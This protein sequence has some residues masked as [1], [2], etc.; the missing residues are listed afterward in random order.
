MNSRDLAILKDLQR[1]RCLSRDDIIDLYFSHLK[2]PVTGAN[3][4]LRRLRLEGHLEVNT[5]VQPYVY[6]ASPSSI[7]KDSTKIPHF[8]KIVECY[9]GLLK[10]EQPRSFIVEPKYGK[11]F[12]EPDAF[13]IW[14]QAPFFVEIQRNIYSEKVMSEKIKR[15]EA[16]F[17][18]EEWKREPWQPVNKKVFPAVIMLT[19][20]RYTIESSNIN[21][22]Q[23]QSIE[24]LMKLYD[25][26][27]EITVSGSL[28]LKTS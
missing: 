10:F 17:M 5:K 7:K 20:T 24:Q 3:M 27:K 6:F 23:V 15:Y 25:R 22:I 4:V 14:K 2:Q 8:L 13:M 19:D 9:K 21:F 12:M 26:P 1:F 28:K 11:G 16:Y 18:S